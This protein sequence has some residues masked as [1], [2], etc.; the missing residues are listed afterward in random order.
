MDKKS[1]SN[2]SQAKPRDPFTPTVSLLIKL[3]S[4]A[5][6]TDELLGPGGEP[7]FDKPAIQTLLEDPEVKEWIDIMT[8][9]AY[10]PV[11]RS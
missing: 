5:V 7:A 8:K 9:Q 10:L 4:I 2:T 3:G 11:K 1:K 6:H